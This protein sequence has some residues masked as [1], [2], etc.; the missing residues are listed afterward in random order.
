MNKPGTRAYATLGA[1]ILVA[2]L[3]GCGSDDNK[4]SN[5]SIPQLSAATA[6]TLTA[7]CDGLS[8][9][10]T[11]ENTTI[12][13]VSTV[14]AGDLTLGG[15]DIAEHCLVTGSMYPR[16]SEVDGKDYAIGFQLR[17]PKDWNGRFYY[18]ANGGLDGSVVTAQGALGGGPVT[19][20]LAKGFA[21]ISSDAGHSPGIPTFGYDPQARLD[22][23]YQAVAKLTPMAKSIIEQVYGKAPDRSYFGGCSN[24]GRHT[25]VAATRYADMYDGFLVGAPGYR[26]P[27]AAVASIAGAQLYASVDDTEASNLNA[28]FT[29]EERTLV[30]EQILAQC[31]SLDGLEDG[32]VQDHKACQ[33]AFDLDTDVPTC[34]SGRDGTCLTEQQKEVIAQIFAGPQTSTGETIYSSFPFDTGINSSGVMFWETYAPLNLDSGAVAMIFN[35]PPVDLAD[36]NIANFN[37]SDFA[38]TSDLDELAANTE[39]TTELYTES[40]MSFMAPPSPEDMSTLKNRGAKIMVYHGV[41]DAIFSIDDTEAW[42]TSLEATTGDA[43]EFA[44]LYPVPGM[45]HC[46]GG[47]ATDQFDMLSPLVAW[48]EQGE[49]PQEIIAT[50]RGTG[51]V[52][53]ENSEIPEDWAADRTRPLCPFPQVARYN[54]SGDVDSADSFT[55]AE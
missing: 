48:V 7:S 19:G 33:E 55:C 8:G 32:M 2:S 37:G 4:S 13:S 35:A 25:M 49:A 20:A 24:G 47:P 44:R 28:A 42:L 34:E 16:T 30:S 54:G 53:G 11:F 10:L 38:L 14:A 23:G 46:S 3:V 29:A 1:A 43:E 6:Q 39:T 40:A 17:L 5:K 51:N 18:Q 27:K 41:S 45:G 22:Y 31:D 9:V 36:F 50:A 12:D 15:H 52:G 21:V 26:L